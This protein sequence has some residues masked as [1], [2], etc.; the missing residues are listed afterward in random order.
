MLYRE[1]LP[2]LETLSAAIARFNVE[3]PRPAMKPPCI[4]EIVP[5]A[6]FQPS[7]LLCKLPGVYA[8]VNEHFVVYLGK[9]SVKPLG[10]RICCHLKRDESGLYIF[11]KE[12]SDQRIEKPT[13]VAIVAFPKD[14]AFEACALEEF[15]IGEI[16]PP[17]NQQAVQLGAAQL[18]WIRNE[19]LEKA[20][21]PQGTESASD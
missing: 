21:S 14:R 9:A 20:G 5:I 16:W 4:D 3:Y 15:L 18:E 13:K 1:N 17:L 7:A 11:D 10:K 8:F 6:S 2:T 12:I 19:L